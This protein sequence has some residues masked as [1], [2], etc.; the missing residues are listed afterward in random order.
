MRTFWDARS[1]QTCRRKVLPPYS[2][3][4][5]DWKS[6]FLWKASTKIHG[7]ISVH[8]RPVLSIL[9]FFLA[10]QTLRSV[11]YVTENNPPVSARQHQKPH[12][13]CTK[14]RHKPWAR[15]IA[16]THTLVRCCHVI[17]GVTPKPWTATVI[18]IA[19]CRLSY[20]TSRNRTWNRTK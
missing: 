20:P 18:P 10:H 6:R 11:C 7:V 4:S 16:L 19:W 13:A 3:Y 5:N 1:I 12:H 9:L 15:R 14:W 8:T 2:F 17:R